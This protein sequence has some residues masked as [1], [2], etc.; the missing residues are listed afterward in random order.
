MTD[1]ELNAILNELTAKRDQKKQ[2][3]LAKAQAEIQTIQRETDAY[4]GGAYDAVKAIKATIPT[5]SK[6]DRDRL[7]QLIANAP[8]GAHA[9]T[10]AAFLQVADY[11]IQNGVTFKEGK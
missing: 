7:A 2:I 11:L 6:T 8:V 9:A 10:D 4:W 1:K 5:P 3:A